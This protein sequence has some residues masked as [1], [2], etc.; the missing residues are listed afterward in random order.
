MQENQSPKQGETAERRKLL[1][2]IYDF[3]E[4]FAI[5]ATVILLIFC[6]LTRLSVVEGDSMQNTLQENDKLLISGLFY[7]PDNGDVVVIQS[8]KVNGGLAIVKRVI[9]TAGQT[10]R[11]EADG[12]VYVFDA[13]GS[14]GVLDEASGALG[15]TVYY[16]PGLPINPYE[17]IELTV[18]E[19]KVFVLGDH[20]NYSYDSR[21]FG[22]VDTAT[23]LGRVYFRILPFSAMRG[24]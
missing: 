21:A 13:D 22:C 23:I 24:F 7:T 5:A 19:G 12:T 17:K 6:F 18:P 2:D 3:I 9:A 11:V 20:R 8:P 14:G 15:Y 4:L 10:V 16:T 1:G